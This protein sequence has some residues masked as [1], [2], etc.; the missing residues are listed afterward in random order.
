MKNSIPSIF[1]R[2]PENHV[3]VISASRVNYTFSRD[4]DYTVSPE[5]WE[6]FYEILLLDK[7]NVRGRLYVVSTDPTSATNLRRVSP[8]EYVVP[9]ELIEA[10]NAVNDESAK[11]AELLGLKNKYIA[12][13]NLQIAHGTLDAIPENLEDDA[14]K[15]AVEQYEVLHNPVVVEEPVGDVVVETTLDVPVTDVVLNTDPVLDPPETPTPAEEVPSETPETPVETA[16]VETPVV[17]TPEVVENKSDESPDVVTQPP[18]ETPTENPVDPETDTPPSEEPVPS[19]TPETS[20]PT[21]DV[22]PTEPVATGPKTS[23][24]SRGKSS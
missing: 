9:E 16:P 2:G 8:E 14:E 12:G 1:Y 19:E 23:P 18:A 7:F 6:D 15:Y 11:K 21:A 13:I 3:S 22:E 10:Q 4:T 5:S 24:R 17:E 20:E